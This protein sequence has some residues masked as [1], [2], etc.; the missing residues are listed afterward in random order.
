MKDFV[1]NSYSFYVLF[2]S[3]VS[4]VGFMGVMGGWLLVLCF[5]FGL[6]IFDFRSFRIDEF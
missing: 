5:F 4:L 3:L 2:L 1:I 6:L